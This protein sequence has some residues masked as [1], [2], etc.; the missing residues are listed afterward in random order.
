MPA[1]QFRIAAS[2][3]AAG[4]ERGVNMAA[5][6]RVFIIDFPTRSCDGD[7]RSAFYVTNLVSIVTHTAHA[8]TCTRIVRAER[9]V[10]RLRLR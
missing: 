6:L 10:M 1:A 7:R 5:K 3:P 2:P 8:T 9:G 4:P